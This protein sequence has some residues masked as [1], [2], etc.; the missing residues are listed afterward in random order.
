MNVKRIGSYLL[1]VLLAIATVMVFSVARVEAPGHADAVKSLLMQDNFD[2]ESL[3]SEYWTASGS[4]V[5][6]KPLNGVMEIKNMVW[7]DTVAF[8][9][10]FVDTNPAFM[11]DNFTVELDAQTLT[12]G[13]IGVAFGLVNPNVRHDHNSQPAALIFY[14]NG[15]PQYDVFKGMTP[16]T[17][18]SLTQPIA[19]ARW[20]TYKF[21]ITKGSGST[22]DAI[23]AS[24]KVEIYL[25]EQG[26]ELMKVG[27]YSG[28]LSNSTFGFFS[29]GTVVQ[30]D[31]LKI[32]S[33]DTNFENV[34]CTFDEN[35]ISYHAPSGN[36]DG[37]INRLFRT[38]HDS[39]KSKTF[40]GRKKVV[41][42]ENTKE[43]GLNSKIAI[44]ADKDNTVAFEMQ[45]TIDVQT[46]A[47]S[48]QFG[49]KFA[50]DSDKPFDLYFTKNAEGKYCIGYTGAE[51]LIPI[52]STLSSTL[53]ACVV[54]LSGRNGGV[55]TVSIDSQKVATIQS[56]GF[57]GTFAFYAFG[58]EAAITATVDDF[59]LYTY[60]F[61]HAEGASQ[62]IGFEGLKKDGK[63]GY[64]NSEKWYLSGN[65]FAAG[66][67]LM[68]T[69]AGKDTAF[70]PN[71]QYDQFVLK[72]DV[73][74]VIRVGSSKSTMI[75][76]SVGRES[77][78]QDFYSSQVIGF[79][80]SADNRMF[81]E[82][83]GMNGQNSD[84]LAANFWDES[85]TNDYT[86]IVV[87]QNRTLSI[88]I[89][90]ADDNDFV[91][92]HPVHIIKDVNTYGYVAIVSSERGNFSIDNV[93]ITPIA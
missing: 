47:E 74:D 41:S 63:K 71:F 21:V 76:V 48:A 77:R 70:G 34:E 92:D 64:I 56:S 45:H 58:D 30:F 20:Y 3:N 46:L 86:V 39:D 68:F 55:I 80:V 27:E 40:C 17:T 12:A 51:S 29:Q 4:G 1:A 65:A 38:W 85:Q 8:Q 53:D 22:E 83:L 81:I 5:S 25:A 66:G 75:G 14:T 19:N 2:A 49:Y 84:A 33:E 50:A 31:N 67:E 18:I 16:D 36:V 52:E 35:E 57:Y 54:S 10:G 59:S 26:K 24:T 32:S 7:G 13:T 73:K 15:T 9:K 23:N 90:N 79:T 43:G 69:E 82:A 61:V 78:G 44:A 87:A 42:F 28:F 60:K 88:Y 37:D 93:S 11:P 6:Q 62:S 89:K 91:L 72:F